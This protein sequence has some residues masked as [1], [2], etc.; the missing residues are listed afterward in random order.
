MDHNAL[1][2]AMKDPSFYSHP[3]YAVEFIQ[4]HISCVFLT[5]DY[6][7]KLKK[8]ADFG[9]LD[10]TTVE[11]R[12]TNCFMELELNRRLAPDVYLRVEPVIV[13]GGRP[14]LGGAA[15]AGGEFPG[16]DEADGEAGERGAAG[17]ARVAPSPIDW[18]VVMRQLDQ[19]LLGL[20]V[21]ERG[22]LDT[23]KIEAVVDRLVPFY[24]AARTGPG[25][26]EFGSIDTVKFNTDEN[27]QQTA[28][29]V[30]RALTQDRYDSIRGFTNG[31]YQEHRDL[32]LERIA[33]GWIRESHG[34][35]H[36]G[37]IFFEDPPVI[38]DC[39]EFNERFRCGDVAVDL[40]FLVMD[41][42]FQGMPELARLVVDRYVER[43]GDTGF[44][45]MVDFYAC[46]RAYV[47]GKIACLTSADP[48]VGQAS[49]AAQL[50]LASRYFDLSFHYA[51][52]GGHGR[53][54][55]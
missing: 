14:R 9:F 15:D 52:Q 2:E 18:V 16:G 36:L 13:E 8:P 22:E 31:F 25:V 37:N 19:S 51:T 5:G 23:A 35:L 38:F 28:E 4:T 17:P 6:V 11:L 34:D 50:Q 21:L 39:I 20:Q 40:A 24:Q 33:Q 12:R 48:A 3:V 47:R 55:T 29:F 53:D 7:F 10:F 26:D 45:K 27:F 32:F 30:G 1:V 46:Y 42:D 43:S 41:L 54:H 49:Q 44:L